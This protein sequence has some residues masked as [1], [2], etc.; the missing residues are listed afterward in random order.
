MT[1]SDAQ[2]DQRWFLKGLK[3]AVEQI[4]GKTTADELWLCLIAFNDRHFYAAYHYAEV[5]RLVKAGLGGREDA[6]SVLID[7][8]L[9][10]DE[11]ASS[12]FRTHRKQA[13]AHVLGCLHNL[14]VIADIMGHVIALSLGLKVKGRISMYNVRKLVTDAPMAGMLTSWLDHAD[15][16][17]LDAVVNFSKHHSLVREQLAVDLTATREVPFGLKLSSFTHHGETFAERWVTD[18][19]PALYDRQSPLVIRVGRRV[20]E[21]MGVDPAPEGADT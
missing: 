21:L 2:N 20:S 11:A 18:A 13:W 12:V 17:Y 7:I 6:Q 5:L 4:R 1:T 9:G 8:V 14:H 15:F 3:D 16:T 19:L 10:N